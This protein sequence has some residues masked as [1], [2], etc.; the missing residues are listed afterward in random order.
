MKKCMILIMAVILFL[1]ACSKSTKPQE[2]V[3]KPVIAPESGAYLADQMVQIS[4]A[5]S[6]ATV[7]YTLDGT[8]PSASSAVYTAQFPISEATTVKAVAFKEGMKP[9]EIARADYTFNVAAITIAPQGGNFIA[10]QMVSILSITQGTV[11]HYTL[12]GSEPGQTSPLYSTPFTL[13]G[14]ALVKARGYKSGWTPTPVVSATFSFT[15]TAPAFNIEGD[16]YYAPFNLTMSSPTAGAQIRYTTDGTDPSGDSDLYTGPVTIQS[17][18]DLKARAYKNNW[19]PSG[20][21]AV[22]YELKAVPPVFY[23]PQ[24]SFGSPQNVALTTA[25]TGAQIRYT[26]NGADPDA[27]SPLYSNPLSI[28]GNV[29]LKARAFMTGWTAS[30]PTSGQYS[31]YVATPVFDPPAG[32]YSTAQTV[33]MSCSTADAEI[34]YTTDGSNPISNSD[35]YTVPLQIGSSTTLKARAFKDNWYDSQVASANYTITGIQTV[36]TPQFSLASGTYTVPQN[37]G[38]TCSTTG[39]TIRYTTDGSDPTAAS[40]IYTTPLDFASDVTLKARAFKADWYDS[41]TAGAD[42]DINYTEGLMVSV[43]GG[44]FTMGR[45]IGSGEADE[46]PTHEVTLSPFLIGKYEVTQSEW[47]AVM[48]SNPSYFTGSL[49]RPVETVNW[50][51]VLAYCNRRSILAGLTP[52]Y[53][54]GGSTDPDDWGEIPLTL[55]DT[56]NAALCNWTANGYRL[57]TEAEW[58]YAARGATNSPD[59][60]YSGSN[61]IGEVAWYNLNSGGETQLIGHLQPNALGIFDLSGNVSEWCWD[62]YGS[63]YYDVSPV[64]N[65]SG[66]DTGAYRMTRGGASDGNNIHYFSVVD[67]NAIYPHTRNLSFG[68]RVARTN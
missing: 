43:P 11:V 36:A 55:N 64:S 32:Q 62:W 38:I 53:T 63:G 12:D 30:N 27:T 15:V 58:E 2:Q 25:T 13:D 16:T 3:A 35:L 45:T 21:A 65:P 54:I 24:G 14:N 56:W 29:M 33:I 22:S 67:R 47:V 26:T 4:C 42:Y 31:F 50:Y 66:P 9:S 46:L 18:T 57:P 39:A 19:N 59:Y 52:V 60:I 6:G 48:G 51:A 5:T 17:S 37:V 28:T 40:D 7:R 49:Y 20:I 23:P 68:F 41:A 34:R 8:D 44:T 10:P 1:A 61:T